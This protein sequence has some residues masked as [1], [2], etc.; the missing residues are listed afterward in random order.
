MRNVALLVAFAALSAC[1]NPQSKPLDDNQ[2]PV[3]ETAVTEPAT[4]PSGS[5]EQRTDLE[6]AATASITKPVALLEPDELKAIEELSN[7][8]LFTYFY[9]TRETG[10]LRIWRYPARREI[11]SEGTQYAISTKTIYMYPSPAASL[12]V[13][14]NAIIWK[15]PDNRSLIKLSAP[16]TLDVY[17]F[18]LK[19]PVTQSQASIVKGINQEIAL[20]SADMPQR[21]KHFRLAQTLIEVMEGTTAPDGSKLH[22]IS[23]F[24]LRVSIH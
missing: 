16:L 23:L 8:I 5:D 19:A 24:P 7:K 22:E 1:G 14:D 18:A 4:A 21:G 20:H 9:G 13:Q 17:S 12:R 11:I 3:A 2:S 15:D 10:N 6:E